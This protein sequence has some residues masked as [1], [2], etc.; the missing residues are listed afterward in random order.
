MSGFKISSNNNINDLF[1]SVSKEEDLD[2]IEETSVGNEISAKNEPTVHTEEK[3]V[4]VESKEISK[5]TINKIITLAENIDSL[6]DKGKAFLSTMLIRTPFEP[7]EEDV[8]KVDSIYGIVNVEEVKVKHAQSFINAVN[9]K[10]RVERVFFLLEFSEEELKGIS[11]ITSL[12][13]GT[14]IS[15]KNSKETTKEVELH[16]E[17]FFESFSTFFEEHASTLK[18][19]FLSLSQEQ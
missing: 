16:M 11:E 5:A 1:K 13:S 19:I 4:E 12:I 18:E 7:G 6:G 2:D 14:E 15:W 3:V 17:E 9:T 8:N 10:D